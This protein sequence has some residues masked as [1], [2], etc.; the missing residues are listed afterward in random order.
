MRTAIVE[1]GGKQ[2]RAVEGSTIDVDR[3]AYEVGK[4]FDFERVLLMIDEDIVMVGTPT[5]GEIKVSATVAEHVKGPKVISFK[6]RPKKR[7]R[8]KGG[9]RH[10]YTRLMIDFIGKPG[11]ERK[12]AAKKEPAARVEKAEV[13]EEAK[14]EKQAKAPKKA[15]TSSPKAKS[16]KAPVAKSPKGEKSATAK[17]PTSKSTTAKKTEKK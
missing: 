16:E 9:H 6:Y 2:Y 7:I 5:V 10:Q 8:V 12:A 3:L 17:K 14:V 15:A 1:S 13:K 4:K 11:E